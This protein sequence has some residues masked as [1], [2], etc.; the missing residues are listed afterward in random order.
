MAASSRVQEDRRAPLSA[1]KQRVPSHLLVQPDQQRPTLA[2]RG[3]VAGPVRRAVAGGCRIAHPTRLT[4]GFLAVNP[5]WSEFC[6][7][8]YTGSVRYR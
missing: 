1:L 8:A 3:V 4:T 7:N 6:N 2:E 5:A